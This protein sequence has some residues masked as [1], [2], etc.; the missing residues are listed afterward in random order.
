MK[1]SKI[2]IQVIA[3]LLAVVGGYNIL[4]SSGVEELPG[5]MMLFTSII[6]NAMIVLTSK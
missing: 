2:I 5:Y 4:T 3:I 6:I 1:V